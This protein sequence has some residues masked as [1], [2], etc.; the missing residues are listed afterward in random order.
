MTIKSLLGKMDIVCHE[1]Y[2]LEWN[3][4]EL[5]L[6]GHQLN[7]RW[8]VCLMF[9]FLYWDCLMMEIYNG[10]PHFNVHCIFLSCPS[11]VTIGLEEVSLP[12]LDVQSKYDSSLSMITHVLKHAWAQPLSYMVYIMWYSLRHMFP[13]DN[14]VEAILVAASSL[15]LAVKC[16]HSSGVPHYL[17]KLLTRILSCWLCCILM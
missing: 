3:M 15:T 6:N 9:L 1:L 8:I 14:C 17:Y 4:V 12:L 2:C 5:V 10:L 16:C 11:V 7:S 13:G